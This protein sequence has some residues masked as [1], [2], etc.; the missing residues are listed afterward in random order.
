MRV[1]RAEDF[2]VYQRALAYFQTISKLTEHFT[3]DRWLADALRET[4]E[5]MLSNIA[6][7]YRQVSD[8]A[9]ARYL[10]IS[11]GSAE[12]SRMHLMAA[13]V[14]GHL[15][16]ERSSALR[17]EVLEIALMLEGLIKYLYRSNRKNRF[18]SDN[19]G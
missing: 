15:S 9:F 4:A 19:R 1:T 2:A 12:E 6:E 8:R 10:T 13:R 14:L 7:G 11:S 16:L 18:Q 3:K 5:S 17:Q